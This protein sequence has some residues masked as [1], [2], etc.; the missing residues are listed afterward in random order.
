M[1]IKSR[2]LDQDRRQSSIV[3][4]PESFWPS[5]MTGAK[6]GLVGTYGA[7]HYNSR[8]KEEWF[9]NDLP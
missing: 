9:L 8:P 7:V 1:L 6:P 5:A 2:L 3:V 4:K